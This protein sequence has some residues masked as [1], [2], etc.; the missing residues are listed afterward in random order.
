MATVEECREALH[1]LATRLAGVDG[2]LRTRHAVDRTLSV[3]LSDLGATF[4]G[5][6]RGGGLHDIEQDTGA[7]AQIRL[8]ATSDDLVAITA[9]A[10]TFPAAWATGRLRIDASPLDLLRLRALL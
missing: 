10:L 9:G 2:D 7:R 4:T 5:A 6:L 8:T 3:H 1:G